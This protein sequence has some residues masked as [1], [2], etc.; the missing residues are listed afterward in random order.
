MK[1]VPNVLSASGLGAT[2]V[3]PH[4][5]DSQPA[6]EAP[7]EF[8]YARAEAIGRAELVRRIKAKARLARA[9]GLQY[10]PQSKAL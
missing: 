5:Q 10:A 8:A 6:L 3:G 9:L 7:A 4:H 2:V 1:G